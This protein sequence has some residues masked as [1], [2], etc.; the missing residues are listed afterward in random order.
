MKYSGGPRRTAAGDLIGIII[1]ETGK[2][3]QF[4]EL[5]NFLIYLCARGAGQFEAVGDIMKHCFPWKQPEILEYHGHALARAGDRL[6]LDADLAIGKRDQSVYAAQ[7]RGLA[8]AG[9]T[10]DR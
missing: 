4:Y 2:P 5:G 3:D 6:A 10:N 7:Q 8:A 1:F 9:G